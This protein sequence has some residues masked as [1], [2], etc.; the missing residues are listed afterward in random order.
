MGKR[1][2]CSRTNSDLEFLNVALSL[3]AKAMEEGPKRKQWTGHDLKTVKPLTSNQEELFHAWFNGH[4]ICTYGCAGT[5][6]SFLSLF[7]A[8][9]SVIDR[10]EQNRIIIVRSA[11]QTR[12]LGF[13]PGTLEEKVMLYELPYEDI[14]HELIGRSSTYQDMKDGGIIE[15]KTTSFIRGLTWDN[16]VI[17]VDEAQNMTFHE[18]DS[19]MTRVGNNSRVIISGDMKQTDLEVRRGSVQ[20]SGMHQLLGVVKNMKEFAT[21]EFTVNDIVR[22]DFVKS[23]IVAREHINA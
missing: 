6:K 17:I 3:N 4:N 12:D 22:S 1:A 14:C 19:V 2:K 23:W 16:A 11:V 7:L 21:I 10:R 8:L 20:T 9:S 13:L 5:G 15:F 18:L